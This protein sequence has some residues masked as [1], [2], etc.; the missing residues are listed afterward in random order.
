VFEGG[1]RRFGG[2]QRF[3]WGRRSLSKRW[4]SRRRRD[5]IF[6]V[7]GN[8]F[9]FRSSL[10]KALQKVSAIRRIFIVQK[11]KIFNGE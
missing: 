2:R 10:C 9:K 11:T 1:R 3:D 8:I 5:F 6:L 7:R 4:K